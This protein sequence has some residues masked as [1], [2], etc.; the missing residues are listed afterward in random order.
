M[1]QGFSN[2]RA[3]QHGLSQCCK[4]QTAGPVLKKHRAR[5]EKTGKRYLSL[6]KLRDHGKLTQESGGFCSD[7]VLQNMSK[8]CSISEK[9]TSVSRREEGFGFS[10]TDIGSTVTVK[11]RIGCRLPRRI[12]RGSVKKKRVRSLR[13]SASLRY[14]HYSCIRTACASLGHLDSR[15]TRWLSE[16]DGSCREE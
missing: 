13:G 6:Y 15:S 9:L 5:I 14:F 1:S 11:G 12:C 8:R 7:L 2:M 4:K 16:A 10:A 3:R